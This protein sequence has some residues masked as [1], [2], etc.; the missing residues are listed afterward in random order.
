[1][2]NKLPHFLHV[3]T[4][5]IDFI[6]IGPLQ[7]KTIPT[8]RV[9]FSLFFSLLFSKS[10]LSDHG[11]YLPSKYL[12]PLL[13]SFLEVPEEFSLV[14]RRRRFSFFQF[15]FFPCPF[16][17]CVSVTVRAKTSE[18]FSAGLIRHFFFFFFFLFLFLFLSF[19]E[20]FFL[21]GVFFFFFLLFG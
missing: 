5:L 15:L 8:Y 10:Y 16:P 11:T 19:V 2:E 12:P 17:K 6:V 13:N 4:G 21:R 3:A 20:V 7:K 18:S 9:C 1:M 14:F